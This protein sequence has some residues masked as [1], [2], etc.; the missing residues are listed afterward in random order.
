MSKLCG[1]RGEVAAKLAAATLNFVHA[2][3]GGNSLISLRKPGM[4][5]PLDRRLRPEF[6]AAIRRSSRWW[7]W[8]TRC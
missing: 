6:T 1:K 5:L 4:S 7:I 3:G 8:L 2:A